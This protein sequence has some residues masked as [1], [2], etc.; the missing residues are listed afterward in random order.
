VMSSD[1]SWSTISSAC[2][3]CA[4][5]RWPDNADLCRLTTREGGGMLVGV[6]AKVRTAGQVQKSLI[7]V[8]LRLTVVPLSM[9]IVLN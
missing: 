4:L 8:S 9:V 1:T 3:T 7:Q 6:L 2:Q 5:G